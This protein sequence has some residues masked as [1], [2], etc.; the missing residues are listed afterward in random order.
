MI[1]RFD[2]NVPWLVLRQDGPAGGLTPGHLQPLMDPL[3]P[4]LVNGSTIDVQRWRGARFDGRL[5]LDDPRFAGSLS[6]LWNTDVHTQAAPSVAVH[7]VT[8][9]VGS[10]DGGWTGT[11]SGTGDPA[12][13]SFRIG[14]SL[15]GS[16]AF[17]G[18][19]ALI[20]IHT[21]DEAWKVE[22][23]VVT[24]DLPPLAAFAD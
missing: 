8:V 2:P 24:G 19:T 11:L 23:L 16:G 15:D 12:T 1:V 18:G 9:R 21:V 22:G 17:T 7:T 20:D 5:E 13:G 6:M 4:W 3:M 14:G 10:A